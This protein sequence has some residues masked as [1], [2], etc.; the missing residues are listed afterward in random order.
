MPD[1]K[2]VAMKLDDRI[3]CLMRVID[4][5]DQTNDEKKRLGLFPEKKQPHQNV[6][7]LALKEIFRRQL[8]AQ[9]DYHKLTHR[10]VFGPPGSD[11]LCS[12]DTPWMRHITMLFDAMIDEVQETRG[13]LNWKSWKTPNVI[14][15][16]DIANA[17]L[18]LIDLIH[19]W[20]NAYSMLGGTAETLVAEFHAKRDEND[21]R[22]RTGY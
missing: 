3:G 21:E 13:W 9:V 17:R 7:L 15:D 2:D 22:Q 20:I 6:G 10:F 4:S 16:N 1:Q 19:F 11:E 18:E 12:W 8:Q 5:S 14:Q